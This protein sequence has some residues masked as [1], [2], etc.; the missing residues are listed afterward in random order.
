MIKGK[1]FQNLTEVTVRFAGDSGDGMQLTGSQFSDTT[2]IWGNDLSTL[3][4]YPA[5]IRAPSGTVYG[6]SGFQLHFGSMEVHTPGDRPDILVAMNPAAIKKNLPELKPGGMIIANTDAFDAKNLKLAKYESNP[7][8]DNSLEG[9]EIYPVPITSLTFKALENTKLSQKDISRCK[10]FFA[11][12]LMYW[13]YNRPL[14]Q[15]IEWI[16]KKFKTKPEYI[17]AN[18]AALEAGYNFNKCHT[19]MVS[20][21]FYHLLHMFRIPVCTS[22]YKCC[23]CTK[24]KRYRVKW[25]INTSVRRCFSL[26]TLF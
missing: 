20:C 11:L 13:L 23:L 16:N 17:E 22:C 24:R 3:P 26:F 2:A 15:T 14:D 9:F 7:L 8:E 5:E 25:K 6:V 19:H 4:D 21:S 10:N 1:E 12:G 18:K